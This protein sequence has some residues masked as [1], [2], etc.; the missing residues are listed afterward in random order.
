[1]RY[2]IVASEPPLNT[3][4]FG[5]STAILPAAHSAEFKTKPRNTKST[6]GLYYAK[7]LVITFL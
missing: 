3:L 7:Q 2:E 1:L 6:N 5:K 4:H